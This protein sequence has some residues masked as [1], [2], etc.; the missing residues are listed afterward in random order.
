ML[1]TAAL[2]VLGKNKDGFFLM[3]EGGAIDWA[4]H[5]CSL[6]GVIEETRDFNTAINSVIAWVEKNS[7]WKETIV[8]ITADHETGYL[9]NKD[10]TAEV[11]N[12][13]SG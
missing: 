3:I 13:S 2:N 6:K 7:S 9:S 5:A 4:S 10:I 12:S 1:S 8:I 11:Y